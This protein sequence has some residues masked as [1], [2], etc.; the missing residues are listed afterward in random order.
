MRIEPTYVS[1][2]L[3]PPEVQ[4]A[5]GLDQFLAR[6]LRPIL[7]CTEADPCAVIPW[8]VDVIDAPP[9]SRYRFHEAHS[10]EGPAVHTLS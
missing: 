3:V 9:C 5:V 6:H 8:R 1:G 2:R 7:R 4:A 10:A